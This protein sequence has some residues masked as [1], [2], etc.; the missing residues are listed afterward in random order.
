MS[1]SAG[2]NHGSSSPGRCPECEVSIPVG[3]VLVEYETSD[4]WQRMFAECPACEAVV[5]P[6]GS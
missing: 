4:G 5:H 6:T 1:G 2:R 3:N